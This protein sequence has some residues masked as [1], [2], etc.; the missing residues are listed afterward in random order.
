[1]NEKTPPPKQVTREV[2]RRRACS[3]LSCS[4]CRGPH[5]ASGRW[6]VVGHKQK[7]AKSTRASRDGRAKRLNMGFT[8][9]IFSS[10][11]GF[12]SE[13]PKLVSE[14]PEQRL[15]KSRLK[16]QASFVCSSVSS[17]KKYCPSL[18]SLLFSCSVSLYPVRGRR[19]IHRNEGGGGGGPGRGG[20]GGALLCKKFSSLLAELG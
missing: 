13:Y 9:F 12:P 19:G 17:C 4:W 3:P 18:H 1:M 7:L 16:R 10:T 6:S 11:Q 2:R 15:N 20:G 5:G 14:R 8:L